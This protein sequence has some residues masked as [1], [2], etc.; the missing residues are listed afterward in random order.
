MSAA[1]RLLRE[2][3]LRSGLTQAQLAAR[4]GTTQS[5]IARMER[6]GAN[7]TVGW[8]DRAMRAMG[9]HIELTSRASDVDESL[10]ASNL[11]LTP[12]ER[13]A[14]FQ[15][16]YRTARAFARAGSQARERPA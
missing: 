2:T 16:A 5:A 9:R 4:M 11:A 10:I 12:A 3:R 15:R 1:A 8:L 6:A 14:R 13:V 7:P